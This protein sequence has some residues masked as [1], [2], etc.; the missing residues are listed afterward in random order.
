M[1][2]NSNL[3]HLR[4]FFSSLLQENQTYRQAEKVWTIA[5]L[6]MMGIKAQL[7]DV[8]TVE[9]P[10]PAPSVRM[11]KD[12]MLLNYSFFFLIVPVH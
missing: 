12:G 2:L 3:S 1:T 8:V 6:W 7:K 10:V 9:K 4:K 5:Q 11:E